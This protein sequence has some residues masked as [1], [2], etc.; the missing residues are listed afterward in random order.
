MLLGLVGSVALTAAAGARRTDTAY[1]RLLRWSDAANVQVIPGCVGLGGFYAAMARLPQVAS[2]SAEVIYELAV[3]GRGAAPAG[4]LEAVASPDGTLG[5]TT[6]RV[7]ILAGQR[8]PAADPADVVIDPQLAT[9]QRLRPGSTLHLIGVPSTAKVCPPQQARSAPGR[10]VP[11]TFR[12]SAVAAFDDQVVPA[13][14][15][16]GAPRVLLSPGFWRSGAGRRFGPGDAANVRLRPGASLASFRAAAGALARRYPSAGGLSFVNLGPQQAAA[17]RAIRPAAVALAVFAALA[18]LLTLAVLCPLIGRQLILDAVEFPTLRALGMTRARLLGL[19]LA[20]A[21]AV[22]CGG[23][24]VA[25]GIAVA[26][27]PLMPVGAARLADPSP[28]VAGELRGTR[29]WTRHHGA[30]TAGPGVPGGLARRRAPGRPAR[31]GRAGLARPAVRDW[32]PR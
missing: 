4:Q 10:P 27:S 25:A 19:S 6:D 30:G 2:M 15:L 32:P 14:G 8:P 12:V 9:G 28:G 20:R 11:L 3:P 16:A 26:A 13:P 7:R 18:G 21:A 22:T 24:L 23:A 31:G 5:V 29:R 17:Q 1:P